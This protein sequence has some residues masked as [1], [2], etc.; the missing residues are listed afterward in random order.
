MPAENP[1]AV[2]SQDF[3]SG[4]RA[5]PLP[6]RPLPPGSAPVLRRTRQPWPPCWPWRASARPENSLRLYDEAI[7]QFS[8]AGAQAGMLNSVAADKDVR[9]QA[10]I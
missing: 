4:R 8:L 7:E 1:A 6:P 10:Q 3:T 9:D 2:A 5:E